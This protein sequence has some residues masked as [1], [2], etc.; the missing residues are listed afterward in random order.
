MRRLRLRGVKRFSQREKIKSFGYRRYQ[1]DM[2]FWT[3]EIVTKFLRFLLDDIR[4][5]KINANV[6]GLTYIKLS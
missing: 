5:V 3:T 4:R 1:S 2:I 6:L